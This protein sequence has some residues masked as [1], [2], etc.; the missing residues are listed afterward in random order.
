MTAMLVLVPI[1]AV[2][3]VA[4]AASAAVIAWWA[5]RLQ[6]RRELWM[7]SSA[8]WAGLV[9]APLAVALVTIAAL[10]SPHPFDACHCTAH[11]LHHPHLC[12]GHPHL[13]AS[14]LIPSLVVLA[15]WM[16][17]A[18]P[19]L[20]R[21]VRWLV[22]ST[23]WV[24]H[25]RGAEKTT[26]AG[27]PML[28]LDCGVPTAFT[29]GAFRPLVVFDRGL[30]NGLEPEARR[31]VLE[32]EIGHVE[33]GDGLTLLA[34]RACLALQPFLPLS[35]LDRWRSAAELACDRRAAD[36]L[37]DP[38]AVAHALVAT[39]ELR[40]GR[41]CAAIPHDAP[42]LGVIAEGGLE[43]RVRVLLEETRARPQ[44]ERSDLVAVAM[45]TLGA[46]LVAVAWP[47]DLLHHAVETLIGVVG[48]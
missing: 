15:A 12:I 37:G 5:D 27:A 11:A 34:L 14:L 13:A 32:H 1:A 31:A 21:F 35:L 41:S 9:V 4:A 23:R 42:V 16:A 3:V 10:A 47:G 33:R 20:L 19:R 2:A 48:H 18:A 45:V 44:R 39:H 8:L 28:L 26:A 29:A 43:D 36:R 30:W 22:S 40:A 25:L 6:A 38:V 17:L 46:C 7:R 24:A